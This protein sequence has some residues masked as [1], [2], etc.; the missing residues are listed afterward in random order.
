[1]TLGTEM[2]SV[3]RSGHLFQNEMSNQILVA[4]PLLL[5]QIKNP[6]LTMGMKT[7]SRS[8]FGG[9]EKGVIHFFHQ[10]YSV[11]SRQ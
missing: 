6:N 11:L 7:L 10:R 3:W 9:I 1:M 5:I 8:N 2:G 4:L